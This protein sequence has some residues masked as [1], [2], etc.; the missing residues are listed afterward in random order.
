MTTRLL[1]T[2]TCVDL[3]R[4]N[5]GVLDRRA[6]CPALVFTTWITAA[7][8]FYGAA[9]SADPEINRRLVD[10]FLESLAVVGLCDL[11]ARVFGEATALLESQR[12]RVEGRRLADADLLIGS[13]A[14]ARQAVVVT[15]NTRHLS[16]IPGVETEDWRRA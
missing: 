6:R 13:I 15:S 2:D 9:K 5:H 4:G 12:R 3:L 16:R 10:R 1:D 8:L 11:S 14:V 7:E